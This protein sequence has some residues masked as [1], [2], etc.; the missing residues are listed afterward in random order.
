MVVNVGFLAA[1]PESKGTK[2]NVALELVRTEVI[3]AVQR[4]QPLPTEVID[5]DKGAPTKALLPDL[6]PKDGKRIETYSHSGGKKEVVLLKVIGGKH[7]YP[8]DINVHRYAWEF[9][10]SVQ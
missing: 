5:C 2:I 1:V 3:T 8:G 7:D 9:F 4:Y 6:D 10:K